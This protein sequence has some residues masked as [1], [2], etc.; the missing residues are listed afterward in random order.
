[1]SEPL[2]ERNGFTKT[3]TEKVYTKN[4]FGSRTS[5]VTF[6]G[7]SKLVE[8]PGH[9]EDD[10]YMYP[11]T[12][13]TVIASGPAGNQITQAESAE[14]FRRSKQEADETMSAAREARGKEAAEAFKRR[15]AALTGDD[16]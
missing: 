15:V 4:G 2:P 1:M 9:P 6:S 11:E 8:H 3:V 14:L 7:I 5:L 12:G 13:R 10:F 16:R